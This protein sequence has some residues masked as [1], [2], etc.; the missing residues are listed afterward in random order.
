[1]ATMES[2]RSLAGGGRGVGATGWFTSETSQAVARIE[3]GIRGIM[4]TM[5]KGELGMAAE[6]ARVV[7]TVM[8]RM[9]DRMVAA[10]RW[11]FA[12]VEG[13]R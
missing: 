5:L 12:R 6:E 1:M 3:G 7:R 10:L 13:K 4:L 2:F 8:R 9:E 11:L